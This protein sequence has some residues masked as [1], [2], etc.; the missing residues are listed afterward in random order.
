MKKFSVV[1]SLLAV[2]V[3]AAIGFSEPGNRGDGIFRIQLITGYPKCQ[4]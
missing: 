3:I 2:V 4:N 1:L